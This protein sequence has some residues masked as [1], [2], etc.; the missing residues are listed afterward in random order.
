V[1]GHKKNDEQMY[2]LQ[3]HIFCEEAWMSSW[4][5]KQSFSMCLVLG[6]SGERWGLLESASIAVIGLRQ[7]IYKFFRRSR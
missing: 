4:K 2:E 3:A 6:R 7:N 5:E 1:E